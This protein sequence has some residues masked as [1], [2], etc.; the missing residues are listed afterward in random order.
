[1]KFVLIS[2]IHVDINTWNWGFL[3]Q[4]MPHTDTLVVAGDISNDVFITSKWI[5]N[6]KNMFKNIIWVA[7][8]HDYYNLGLHK[9][10]I[11][12]PKYEQ[13]WPYPH[14]V[15][16]IAEHYAKWSLANEIYFLNRSSAV[17]NG[18]NFIG[19]T[20]WH[21]FVAGEPFSQDLQ[22]KEY[23]KFNDRYIPWRN[24]NRE[25]S[26][27]GP[28]EQA[29]LDSEFLQTE[30]SK[31]DSPCVVVTHHLPH[32]SL[33][34]ENVADINWTMGHGLFVNTL[35]ENVQ[36]EKVKIWCFGH[37][38]DRK[39]KSINGIDY[40]CNPRGYIGENKNWTPILID[41]NAL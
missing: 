22:I 5:K 13:E 30:I 39:I 4:F 31:Q 25:N 23:Y 12:N 3:D 18:V 29:K 16:Q 32:R 10:R 21:D 2:D 14:Y 28:L 9:T 17:V 19:A 41:L 37:T 26:H 34:T 8:N 38:H 35:L 6:A 15:D 11:Y 7:G 1:M 36:A 20:G 24:L 40:V 33:K 27:L